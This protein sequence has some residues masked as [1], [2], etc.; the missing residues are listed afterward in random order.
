MKIFILIFT[1]GAGLLSAGLHSDPSV[2][3][4]E[5][6]L[7]ALIIDGENNHGIWPKTTM[8]MKDFLEQTGL[9][10][11]DI[12]R[13]AY[14]WQ[15]PHFDKSIGLDDI[16]E[17]LSMYPLYNGQKTTAVDEPKPDPDYCPAFE[18]YDVVI[19]NF[20]WQ[21]SDWP[22]STRK[23]FEKYMAEGGGLVVVHAANNSWGDWTEYNKMIGIGGWGGRDANSGTYANL[24]EEGQLHHDTPEGGCG[25]HGP[26]YEYLMENRAPEHPIMKGLPARWMHAKDELYDRLCGPAENMTILI[27]AYSDEE[28]NSPPW[29][30]EM[31][32]TGR[33]EP[34]IFTVNYGKGRVFHTGLG[35]MGYSMECVGFI[36]TF[37]RGVEWA[38]TGKVTQEVPDDFPGSDEISIRKWE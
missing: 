4:A 30:K 24:D 27:T 10:E 17:L 37:Q 20:G 14:T 22:E 7:K 5:P 35:H 3:P 18:D 23:N 19:S 34:L 36:T 16:K 33:H 38:A 12:N 2:E 6:K 32:G 13:T 25:S 28:K 9:F 1:L 15:G 31:S 26:Q 29:N 11:V 21:A 8:M